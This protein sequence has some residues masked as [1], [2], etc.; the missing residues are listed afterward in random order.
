MSMNRTSDRIASLKMRG[1]KALAVSLGV[2]TL[3]LSAHAGTLHFYVQKPVHQGWITTA[4]EFEG[5][6]RDI[7]IQFH[8][9]KP[10]DYR[11]AI[12]TL[13]VGN[14]IDIFEKN[15]GVIDTLVN[16][17]LVEDVSDI[18]R[19]ANLKTSLQS[20]LH[21]STVRGR[22]WGI[23]FSYYNWGIYY[24]KDVFQKLGIA[25]PTNWNQLLQACAKLKQAGIT[26]F[27]IGTK[28]AWVTTLWFD[29]LNL[30][31]NGYDF[32]TKLVRD[33]SIPFTHKK[34]NAVFDHWDILIK[35]GYFPSKH[36]HL[37]FKD[38]LLE[39]KRGQAA[40]FLGG[41]FFTGHLAEMKF[42]QENLGFIPFPSVVRGLAR[43]EVA[44]VDSIHIAARSKN[45]ADAKRF[46]LYMASSKAQ[47]R[48]NQIG[49]SLPVHKDA[50]VG[51][52]PMMRAGHTLL[53]ETTFLVQAFDR[54]APPEMSEAATLGFRN[55][56]INPARRNTLLRHLDQVRLRSY[57]K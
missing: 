25:P 55:Y 23:P 35:S 44:P 15:S 49:L 32:H 54:E 57:S 20:A 43:S 21:M 38:S 30:R 33:G 13:L 16:D 11:Y 50:F 31:I 3:W 17:N 1:L 6:N 2:F 29:Y 5:L 36:S 10:S 12:P 28:D 48:I 46:L 22:Q 34:V 26:P 41:L 42:P 19:K 52:N 56:M 45:K 14:D 39:F 4:R 24:R 53:S 18:W 51:K 27:T 47:A 8:E 40:M 37:S 9:V 7:R